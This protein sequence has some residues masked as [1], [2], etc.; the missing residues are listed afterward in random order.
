MYNYK[1]LVN[2][3]CV[4]H[5]G[6][7]LRTLVDPFVSDNGTEYIAHAID[8]EGNE[9]MVLWDVVNSDTEDESESCDWEN[10]KSIN[11]L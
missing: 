6:K 1:D 2:C 4:M 5:E 11:R 9:Y 3:T 8:D 10:P 7:E